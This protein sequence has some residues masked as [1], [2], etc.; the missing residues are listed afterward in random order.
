LTQFIN[1]KD[2]G[3][4]LARYLGHY[5]GQADVLVLALPRGGIPVGAEVARL[6]HAPLDVILVRK[7]GVPGQ[8]ELAMGAIA[9]G[10][11]RVLNEDVIQSLHISPE[12]I[13]QITHQE[14]TELARR[15]MAYRRD[16][17]PVDVRDRTVILT[18]DGL[19]TGAS[20]YAAVM[21][22]RERHP[23]RVVVAVPV[24]AAETVLTFQKLADEVICALTPSPFYGV[25]AWYEDF[26]QVDDEQVR[27]LLEKYELRP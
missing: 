6:L 11:L 13:E 12:T 8:E 14:Q 3:Q 24:A 17:A 20:M 4:Q 22:I 27:F 23:A 2:A 16:R 15:E 1:R 26:S 18:D 19:A 7:L 25:G 5:I 10:G 21:V 9:S